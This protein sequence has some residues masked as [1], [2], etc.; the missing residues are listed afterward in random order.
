MAL[1]LQGITPPSPSNY[2]KEGMR[3]CTWQASPTLVHEMEPAQENSL[4]GGLFGGSGTLGGSQAPRFRV[5]P[6]AVAHGLLLTALAAAIARDPGL[7]CGIKERRARGLAQAETREEK[8]GV[9]FGL[10][11]AWGG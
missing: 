11:L 7:A 9:W 1:Q 3:A 5:S 6:P 10:Y 4:R 8:E 2:Y